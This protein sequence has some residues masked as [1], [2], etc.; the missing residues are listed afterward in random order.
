MTLQEMHEAVC[1]KHQQNMALTRL[2]LW[3]GL[4]GI[5]RAVWSGSSPGE[6]LTMQEAVDAAFKLAMEDR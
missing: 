6:G 3:H 2:T 1:A 5:W 4:T